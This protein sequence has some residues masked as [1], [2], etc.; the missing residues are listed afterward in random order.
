MG[1]TFPTDMGIEGKQTLFLRKTNLF[2]NLP[3]LLPGSSFKALAPA[4]LSR[5]GMFWNICLWSAF[6]SPSPTPFLGFVQ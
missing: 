1:Q 4:V 6:L 3:R 2:R 5:G